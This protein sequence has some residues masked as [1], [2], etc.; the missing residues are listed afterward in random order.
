MDSNNTKYQSLMANL[1]NIDTYDSSLYSAIDNERY[2]DVYKNFGEDTFNEIYNKFNIN[3]VLAEAANRTIAERVSEARNKTEIVNIFKEYNKRLDDNIFKML[4]SNLD[5]AKNIIISQQETEFQ[6]SIVKWKK[7]LNKAQNI[8]IETNIWPL[9]IGF[10][11]I[12][13]KTENKT[14]YAPLFFKEILVEVRNSLVYI[15]SNSDIRVNSKLVT[16]LNQEGFSLNVDSFDF[17]GLSIREVFERFKKIWSPLFSMPET[18]KQGIKNLNVDN[19][20]NTSILFHSG[21]VLGFFNV[22]SGYLWNQMKKIIENDEFDKILQPNVNKNVYRQK[23]Q[24]VIFD[25]NFKLFKIQET[26]YSQDVATV[27]S[28]YQDTIIWGPPGTGKSQTISNLI[29]NIIARGY[30]ALVVSQKKAALDVLKNR[31]KKLSIFCLFALNDKNLRLETFYEPLREFIYLIENYQKSEMEEGFSVFSDEDKNYVDNVNLIKQTPNLSNIINFYAAIMNGNFNNQTYESL[32]LLDPSLKY[33][34]SKITKDRKELINTLYEA[35]YNKRRTIFTIVPGEIKRMADLILQDESLFTIDIDEALKY[36]NSVSYEEIVKFSEQYKKI[37]IS[38]TLKLNDDK[39]L[40]KIL[41]EKTFEKINNFTEEQ[42]RQ[43]TSF[44]MAIRIG[45]LKPYKFFHKH[46]EMIKFLFPIIVTTPELDLSMWSKEE[47]DYAILDE[48]SQVFLEKGIPIL[49]LAKRK[50][51]AGDNQQMQPTR[52]FSASYSFDEEDDFGNI[53]SLLDYAM[54][55]GVYSVL[56]DKNYRSKKATL[57][58]FSSKHFYESKLDVID[59]Y[60][61]SLSKDKA[62]EVIQ[63]DGTWDNSMN[64]AEGLKVIEL[65]R[66]NIKIYNK[67]IILLFNSKQQDY[68]MNKIFGLEPALEEA[69]MNEKIIIKN[70]E[71]VQGDEADL[72]IMSVVYDK[73]TSLQNTYVARNG[74][75]NALNVA[76][77]RA[78]EKVMVVKSIYADDIE[79]SDKSTTDMIMFRD[80]LKFLDLPLESQKNYLD[81]TNDYLATKIN[82]I[83]EDLKFKVDVLDSLKQLIIDKPDFK[84][85]VNYSVGTKTIDIVLVNNLNKKMVQGFILDIFSYKNDYQKY[86]IFRDS[87]KFLESKEYPI[88]YISEIEWP[89]NKNK[90]FSYLKRVIYEES[91]INA[92]FRREKENTAKKLTINDVSYKMEDSISDIDLKESFTKEN[93]IS[94]NNDAKPKT[95]LTNKEIKEDDEIDDYPVDYIEDQESVSKEIDL[96]EEQNLGENRKAEIDDI[97]MLSEPNNFKKN[98]P[99]IELKLEIQNS[100]EMNFAEM[101]DEDTDTKHD[102]LVSDDLD[103]DRENLN[104]NENEASSKNT[105]EFTIISNDNEDFETNNNNIDIEKT[106]EIDF[107]EILAKNKIDPSIADNTNEHDKK[108]EIETLP[109]LN[110]DSEEIIKNF[111]LLDEEEDTNMPELNNKDSE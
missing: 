16:F 84:F 30:T 90:I 1:L 83:P 52:W 58:T 2:F 4:S 71:N 70:I 51:L 21:I 64:E 8:N 91:I 79:I 66:E 63:V 69:L 12:S 53:K 27:S 29:T 14:I 103:K 37:L 15:S 78:R 73:N 38:K 76:I 5:K 57:M 23:V 74:G 68:L 72:V 100:D 54:V 59:N 20:K 92:E 24:K 10:F 106:T 49:Y 95:E 110:D 9:H 60:E 98:E 75:K 94:K 101:E 39:K 26:N 19:I 33:N 87:I 17:T 111:N 56:L 47:F 108:I 109:S 44:A 46:K 55:L 80:W 13:I 32:K 85:E 48:S 82:V 7:I 42:K 105:E 88:I 77:S 22:S 18:L 89:I 40:T 99:K 86:L 93:D 11:Y 28:L 45:S 62:I 35:N 3:C 34:L 81:E 25:D 97:D 61:L 31:M 104:I 50:I 67:I 65:A 96:Y 41:L 107:D 6:K 102:N 43:Y 36:V